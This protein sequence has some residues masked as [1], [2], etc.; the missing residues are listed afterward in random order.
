MFYTV[1]VTQDKYHAIGKHENLNDAVKE[2][3]EKSTHFRTAII[4]DGS[5][6]KRITRHMITYGHIKCDYKATPQ[7]E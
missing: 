2:M 7:A 6:G 3:F 5:T 4:R 1:W